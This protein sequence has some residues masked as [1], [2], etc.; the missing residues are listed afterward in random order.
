V[1][2]DLIKHYS[3]EDITIVWK[4][5]VCIHSAKCW[6]GEEGLTTV[7]NPSQR[8]W[9][10]PKGAKTETIINQINKC[11]SGAL[12]YIPKNMKTEINK[13]ETTS[14]LIEIAENGPFLVHGS[15]ILKDKD[16]NI[17]EKDKVTALCRCGA[18][19]KKPFCDGS[20]RKIDFKG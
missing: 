7:F 6:R 19:S 12:T 16:G 3:N 20:H 8:P 10:K 15:I 14:T 5:S 2:E 4:P 11:P 13:D 9:I 18:S 1:K 17:T